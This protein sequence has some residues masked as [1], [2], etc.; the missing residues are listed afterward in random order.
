MTKRWMAEITYRGGDWR[1]NFGYD[2]SAT[3]IGG[4]LLLA[5]RQ[6][7]RAVAL[8]DASSLSIASFRSRAYRSPR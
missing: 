8:Y 7:S 1:L 4:K 2:L 6:G 5:D 3:I